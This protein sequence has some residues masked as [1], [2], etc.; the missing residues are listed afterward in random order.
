M[1]VLLKNTNKTDFF[2][3]FSELK[4]FSSKISLLSLT[5]S[6]EKLTTFDTEMLTQK[7]HFPIFSLILIMNNDR[8]SIILVKISEIVT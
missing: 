5:H 4:C 1:F 8:E 7:V 3:I 6:W 2:L